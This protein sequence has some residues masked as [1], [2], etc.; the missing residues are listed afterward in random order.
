MRSAPSWAV[1]PDIPASLLIL[2][3]TLLIPVVN[4]PER[5]MELSSPAVR[6]ALGGKPED[7]G[8]KF[9][10]PAIPPLRKPDPPPLD[11]SS[12]PKSTG[13]NDRSGV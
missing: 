2:S 5:E 4:P 13:F 12:P 6:E 7:S 1:D 8:M 3:A 10:V 11:I 9:R